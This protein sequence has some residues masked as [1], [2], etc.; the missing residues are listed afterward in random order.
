M[1]KGIEALAMIGYGCV[2]LTSCKSLHE[3]QSLINH[4]LSTGI[5]Y[6]DTAPSYGL[7]YSEKIL[8]S[9]LLH[10]GIGREKLI[11]ATKIGGFAQEDSKMPASLALPLKELH[12]R[13][14][15]AHPKKH[16]KDIKAYDSAQPCPVQRYEINI[17]N[18][19]ASVKR[20]LKSLKTNYVDI[21]LLHEALPSFLTND[22]FEYILDL[23]HSGV[24]RRIGIAANGC[25][26][27]SLCEDEIRDWDI[28]QY[29]YGPAW[30]SHY[31]FRNKFPSK[32]HVLHSC[33]GYRHDHDFNPCDRLHSIIKEFP[34]ATVL[35]SSLNKQHISVN[36]AIARSNP[37]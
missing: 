28:L 7:G 18:V 20:S 24:A 10:S 29:E 35:F 13:L 36:A 12:R 27:E 2:R 4:I 22:A 3:A 32:Q 34:E 11:I 31:S 1:K 23:K 30:P 37:L 6:F 26:Y 16:Y 19:K 9:C 33:V 15:N 14:Q 17:D 21:L 5:R 8:G 25:N